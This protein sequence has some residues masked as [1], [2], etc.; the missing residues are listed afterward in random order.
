MK[1]IFIFDLDDTLI[2]TQHLYKLPQPKLA[3][4]IMHKLNENAV[5]LKE[6]ADFLDYTDKKNFD[7]FNK[8]GRNPY[9]LERYVLSFQETFEHFCNEYKVSYNEKEVKQIRGLAE[10]ISQTGKLVKKDTYKVLNYLKNIKKDKIMLLTRGEDNFQK[11]KIQVNGLYEYFDER[12][13]Y[14][15]SDKNAKTI[16]K[17][18]DGLD[19]D[20]VFL[21]DNAPESIQKGGIVGINGILIPCKTWN[22][23][24][25]NNKPCIQK[26]REDFMINKLTFLKFNNIKDII[27]NYDKIKAFLCN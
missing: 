24:S 16:E 26:I 9:S 12:D 15:K 3:S 22:H 13:C 27:K 18:V 21:V 1:K 19:R 11:N 4:A 25:Y 20:K 10:R 17:V 6:I 8:K 23:E 14:I 5:E 7:I 2:S